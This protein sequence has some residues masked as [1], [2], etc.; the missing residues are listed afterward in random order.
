MLKVDYLY[1][2]TDDIDGATIHDGTI[3]GAKLTDNSVTWAKL[4]SGVQAWIRKIG[5][6]D[7]SDA[8]HEAVVDATGNVTEA[9]LALDGL[10]GGVEDII[11]DGDFSDAV[12]LDV[13]NADDLT[14]A[15]V[16]IGKLIG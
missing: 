9:V 5:D 11:G 2:D 14:D 3:T 1:E 7:F 13:V 6:A 12:N 4:G 16:K 15:V 10:V 8:V